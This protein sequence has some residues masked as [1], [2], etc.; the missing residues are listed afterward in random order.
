MLLK[1]L[2]L[3]YGY[4][5]CFQCFVLLWDENCSTLKCCEQKNYR[6]IKSYSVTGKWEPFQLV[7]LGVPKIYVGFL[8]FEGYFC[9][10]EHASKN[11][12]VLTEY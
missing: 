7:P 4:L 2:L 10:Y 12:S 1:M 3:A 8:A 9:N 11:Q 6:S 5:V